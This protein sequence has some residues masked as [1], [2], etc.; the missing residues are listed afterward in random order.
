MDRKTFAL[1]ALGGAALLGAGFLAIIRPGALLDGPGAA[2]G[3]ARATVTLV[4]AAGPTIVVP[5]GHGD[6]LAAP[7]ADAARAGADA[8]ESPAGKNTVDAEAGG[9]PAASDA[10]TAA[11][12]PIESGAPG[13]SAEPADPSGAP[14]APQDGDDRPLP[15]EWP[16]GD[17]SAGP[18]AGDGA[19]DGAGEID[20]TLCKSFICFDLPKI[21]FVIDF[22]GD[23]PGPGAGLDA[24]DILPK[25]TINAPLLTGIFYR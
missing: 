22:D 13:D 15:G 23:T 10:G 12:A 21:D 9:P 18:P 6:A 16:A 17:A 2:P 14:A 25:P 5:V 20:L 8:P 1:A 11:P 19:A 7:R 4:K 3:P 24:D